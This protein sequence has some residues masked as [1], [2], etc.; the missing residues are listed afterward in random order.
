V[1][2]ARRDDHG[3]ARWT[4]HSDNLSPDERY[5]NA[6]VADPGDVTRWI[7]GSEAG[8]RVYSESGA[9][10]TPGDLTDVPVRALLATG[11]RFLAGTDS[12]AVFSS[13][14]GLSW[15]QLGGDLEGPVYD[16]CTA[17]DHL[18]AATGRGLAV[19]GMDGT[20]RHV[21]PRMLFACV[22]VDPAQPGRWLAGASPGG[23]WCT[24]DEGRSWRQLESFKRVRA[25]LSPEERI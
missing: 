17:R 18:L 5:T 1:A 22:A 15:H 7:A 3:A 21:G 13:T 14:D 16:L 20:W 24:E 10:C 8:V 11:G 25:I 12:A 2:S 9:R 19:G 6:V 23:V 4:F